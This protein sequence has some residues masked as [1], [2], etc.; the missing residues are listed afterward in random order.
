M[1]GLNSKHDGPAAVNS[2][3]PVSDYDEC[4]V[5]HVFRWLCATLAGPRLPHPP[6]K[7]LSQ[8]SFGACSVHAWR[9]VIGIHSLHS[10]HCAPS[11]G[12]VPRTAECGSPLH[13]AESPPRLLPGAPLSPAQGAQISPQVEFAHQLGRCA[14]CP[15]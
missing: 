15:V 10:L 12:G 13:R 3:S 2:E 14:R 8:C 1:F 9:L 7:P 6:A 5:F 4:R 11:I